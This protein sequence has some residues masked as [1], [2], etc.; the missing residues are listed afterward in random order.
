[1]EAELETPSA[2]T[3]T[4]LSDADLASMNEMLEDAYRCESEV[5]EAELI[6]M[7]RQAN[8]EIE[9][10]PFGDMSRERYDSI[11]AMMPAAAAEWGPTIG[12]NANAEKPFTSELRRGTPAGPD[13]IRLGSFFTTENALTAAVLFAIRMVLARDHGDDAARES[14]KSQIAYARKS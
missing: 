5:T 10:S 13:V 2:F 7:E 8:A 4:G 3:A 12:Y 1:M 6:E 11:M 9:A 14:I